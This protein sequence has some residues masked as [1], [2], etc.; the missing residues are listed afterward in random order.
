MPS[1]A[2]DL[3]LN[4]RQVVTREVRG[5]Y[6][7]PSAYLL[8]KLTLDA[9]ECV[10]VPLSASSLWPICHTLALLRQQITRLPTLR[11]LL[12]PG[13]CCEKGRHLLARLPPTP[14]HIC[15]PCC[16]PQSCCASS[17]PSSTSCPSTTWQA[18]GQVR[19]MLP[20]ALWFTV[21]RQFW[22]AQ[23]VHDNPLLL[24]LL[25]LPAALSL[26]AA[27]G[28]AY[29]AA[30]CFILITFSCTV[31]AMSMS[32]TGGWAAVRLDG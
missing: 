1:P 18:S 29:A 22:L 20:S 7:N 16:L 28:A 30:Y 10:G 26:C 9:S 24:P 17:P 12:L 4:E 27:A 21:L 31:G 13:T 15:A 6:Y 32:V 11:L 23:Q 2:V 14:A 5:G 3:L 8:S 25:A 19:C